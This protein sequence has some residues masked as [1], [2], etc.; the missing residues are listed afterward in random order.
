[1]GMFLCKKNCPYHDTQTWL[2]TTILIL[3]DVDVLNIARLTTVYKPDNMRYWQWLDSFWKKGQETNNWIWPSSDYT[4]I[5]ISLLRLET[6]LKIIFEKSYQWS[7]HCS[8]HLTW[9]KTRHFEEMFSFGNIQVTKKTNKIS[10]MS[11]S[12]LV[13]VFL[14]KNCF[15]ERA[16]LE[17]AL[18]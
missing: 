6:L 18:L 16:V 15:I 7:L 9:F 12:T 2:H 14:V 11:I 4:H 8:E 5:P 3:K 17:D 1:M 10:T 13:F